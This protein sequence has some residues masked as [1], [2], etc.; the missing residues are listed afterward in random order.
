MAVVGVGVAVVGVAFDHEKR[1]LLS[2][3]VSCETMPGPDVRLFVLADEQRETGRDVRPVFESP[4]HKKCSGLSKLCFPLREI[5]S[6]TQN[7]LPARGGVES[8]SEVVAFYRAPHV[9]R[10]D[11][12]RRRVSEH[13]SFNNR[14][15]GRHNCVLRAKKKEQT[16]KGCSDKGIY[17]SILG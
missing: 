17:I 8:S 1:L 9:P 7:N 12:N 5:F 14:D 10:P 2:K 13:P 16:F 15:L 4:E 11:F 6:V 3:T